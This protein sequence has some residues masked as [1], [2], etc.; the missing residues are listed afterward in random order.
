MV[1]SQGMKE[2][3]E[4]YHNGSKRLETTASGINVTAHYTHNFFQ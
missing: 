2:I 1:S 3:V 4:L